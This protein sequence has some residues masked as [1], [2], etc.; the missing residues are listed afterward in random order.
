MT[1]LQE[2]ELIERQ[3]NI[4][5]SMKKANKDSHSYK[6]LSYLHKLIC[7]SLDWNQRAQAKLMNLWKDII[8]HPQKYID[9]EWRLYEVIWIYQ[10]TLNQYW[11]HFDSRYTWSVNVKCYLNALTKYISGVCG[12]RDFSIKLIK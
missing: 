10:S 5:A 2:F 6:H 4:E 12:Y 9:N 7:L 8:L 3:M 11:K 1:E